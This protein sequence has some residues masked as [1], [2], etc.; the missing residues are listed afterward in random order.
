MATQQTMGYTGTTAAD[1]I[2]VYDDNP[3]TGWVGWSIFAGVMLTMVGIFQGIAGFV[4]LFNDTFYLVGKSGLALSVDYTAWGW[5]HIVLG[6]LLIGAGVS[7][8]RGN[9]YGR[10]VGVVV[11]MISAI[12]NLVFLPAY[13]VWGAIIITIDILVIWALTAHGRE[14][15]T[16]K[17]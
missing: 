14:L 4:A 3:V 16:P 1:D 2:A 9:M 10:I 15:Q 6:A 17:S 13:P 7:V 11:A 5:A 8:M 12:A